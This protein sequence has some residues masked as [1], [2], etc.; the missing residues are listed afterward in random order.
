[1]ITSEQIESLD[2]DERADLM[3][4]LA[5]LQLPPAERYATHRRLGRAVRAVVTFGAVVLVP[6]TIYLAVSLPRRTM[7]NHWRAAWVGFDLLLAVTLALTAWCAWHRL[8]LVVIGLGASAVLLVCDAWF[9][10]MLTQGPGRWTSLAMAILVELPVAAMFT[11]GIY[12]LHRASADIL[13]SLSGGRGERP[14]LVR[15]PLV[16]LLVHD[17][18]GGG[19][20]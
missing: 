1:M 11:R 2:E 19:P 5:D 18:A 7:T 4:R 8:Q 16:H 14:S 3:R 17:D 13:W 15:F 6:W 9:D 12:D 20:A 10:V